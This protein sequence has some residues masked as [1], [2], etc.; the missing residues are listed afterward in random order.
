MRISDWSSDVCSSDLHQ[1]NLENLARVVMERDIEGETWALPDTVFGTD[2]HTTMINGIGVL[3][4]GVGGIKAEAAMLG[5]AS[6]MLL[7][8][9][10]GFELTRQLTDGAHATSSQERPLG[11]KSVRTTI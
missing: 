6:S 7:P 10:V 9:V 11:Q 4:W 1:V 3:G 2:S 5:Q 8:H